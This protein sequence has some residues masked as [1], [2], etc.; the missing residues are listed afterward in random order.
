ML[1]DSILK[2]ILNIFQ[3]KI[4]I[5]KKRKEDKLSLYKKKLEEKRIEEIKNRINQY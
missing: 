5:L 3:N 4:S 2:E 1:S